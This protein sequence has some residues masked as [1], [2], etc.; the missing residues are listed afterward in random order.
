MRTWCIIVLLAV[1]LAGC[2]AL[3]QAREDYQAGSQG[4]LTAGETGLIGLVQSV[5]PP[6][7]V[8]AGVLL[9]T[10][11]RWRAGR[12]IRKGLPAS[13]NPIT[14]FI[15]QKVG[16]E[17]AVQLVADLRTGLFDSVGAKDT[18]VNRGWKLAVLGGL[19]WYAAHVSGSNV[20]G[21][22]SL[23]AGGMAEKATQKVLPVAPASEVQP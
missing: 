4:P 15:G 18:A 8:P 14:G 11:F 2:A 6:A 10:L 17:Q 5:F 19:A 23:V 20:V 3:N 12:R 16:L 9:T 22:L 1:G 7:S 21:L 13:S